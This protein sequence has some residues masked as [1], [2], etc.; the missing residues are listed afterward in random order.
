M[1]AK[2]NVNM[3]NSL[4]NEFYSDMT[5]EVMVNALLLRSPVV[6][7]GKFSFKTD[8]L[9]QGYSIFTADDIPGQDKLDVNGLSVPVFAKDSILYKGQPV[10]IVTGPDVQ[11]LKKICSSLTVFK[12]EDSPEENRQEPENILTYETQSEGY[13]EAL[14]PASS[15][16]VSARWISDLEDVSINE[17]EG[18]FFS[19]K[20]GNYSIF[21]HSEDESAISSAVSTVAQ[22]DASNIE[23]IQT[24]T[25]KKQ[26][27][28][29]WQT[30]L[31]CAQVAVAAVKLQKSV[32]LVFS[33]Q[34]QL[35]FVV[36]PMALQ[37]NHTT[38]LDENGKI[39][40]WNI[41]ISVDAGNMVPDADQ[42]I[43]RFETVVMGLYACPQWKIS[44]KI[45]KTDNPP[46]SINYSSVDAYCNFALECHFNKI[47]DE[48]EADPVE[49][50]ILNVSDEKEF[51]PFKSNRETLVHLLT[52]IKN[53]C[54]FTRKYV[55]YR[56]SKKSRY[57]QNNISPFLPPV[58]GIGLS[59]GANSGS[60]V[61][62]NSFDVPAAGS[63][64]VEMDFDP[65]SYDITLRGVWLCINAGQI[66]REEVAN[67]KNKISICVR[68]VLFDLIDDHIV[69][70]ERIEL[71]F[72]N[73]TENS[74]VYD[75][76]A[77]I[78]VPAAFMNALSQ[79]LA[80]FVN[81]APVSKEQIYQIV[82]NAQKAYEEKM[83]ILKLSEKEA[84]DL[85]Q[86]VSEQEES[87]AAEET[88]DSKQSVD[89]DKNE[90]E[91]Q[92]NP[93]S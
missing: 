72:V 56:L 22:I 66:S 58:R 34:E 59:C 63:C 92:E 43:T 60:S 55:A 85:K 21:T 6:V 74:R 31:L 67:I 84:G 4:S 78:L 79:T 62:G 27:I 50:R 23:V 69:Q 45:L 75:N 28:F 14:F 11:V 25:F 35:D 65:S 61:N 87:A 90:P 70:S 83:A 24:K 53:K 47:A 81:K 10:G 3:A 51:I 30:A 1:S 76:I 73:S 2:K 20:N 88:S 38:A 82:T 13:E 36:R 9:P 80:Q 86:Q 40:A 37:I 7:K 42:L 26:K 32:K 8:E 15:H 16:V 44:V 64:I 91:H 12:I 93:E 57:A 68:N 46:V 77:S 48:L 18:V 5:D 17:T 19:Y 52:S 39:N 33:R 71:L 41:D 54:D 49:L 89:F 29:G